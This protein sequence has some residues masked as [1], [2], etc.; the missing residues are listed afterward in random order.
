MALVAEYRRVIRAPD[1]SR[2][3][4]RGQV[5]CSTASPLP[6]A[7][8]LHTIVRKEKE[9][10]KSTLLLSLIHKALTFAVFI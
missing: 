2:V 1:T 8:A 6:R 4:P 5:N 7:R 10:G 9:E 3:A